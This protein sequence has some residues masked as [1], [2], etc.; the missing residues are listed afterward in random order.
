M[1]QEYVKAYSFL[2]YQYSKR[3]YPESSHLIWS[4]FDIDAK[5]EDN[6]TPHEILTQMSKGVFEYKCIA[7]SHRAAISVFP[8]GEHRKY[9]HTFEWVQIHEDELNERTPG[10]E[11]CV[12]DFNCD[13]SVICK[14][15]K[16]LKIRMERHYSEVGNGVEYFNAAEHFLCSGLISCSVNV[17]RI[18]GLW[19][20]D[21]V[22]G[23]DIGGRIHIRAAIKELCHQFDMSKLGLENT[24]EADFRFY[25]RKTK[26]CIDDWEVLP[27]SKRKKGT[28]K[29]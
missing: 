14:E 4:V 3:K 29:T 12:I 17:P 15:I 28:K 2:F 11:A 1:N 19:L 8:I 9:E 6:R 23:Y 25:L 5:D 26:E 24:E 18:V 13:L 20:W 7:M 21:K 27:F 22:Y 10:Y 16:L